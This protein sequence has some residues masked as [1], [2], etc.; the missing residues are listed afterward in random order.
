MIKNITISIISVSILAC[1]L[2][3]IAMNFPMTYQGLSQ[4]YLWQTLTYFLVN[5]LYS[6]SLIAHLVLNLFLLNLIGLTFTR[7]NKKGL[8]T[9][10]FFGGAL[11]GGLAG[12]LALMQT[13]SP[14]ALYGLTPPLYALMGA[15]AHLYPRMELFVF[16][17]F[18]LRA[19][20]LFTVFLGIHLILDLANGNMV[21]LTANGSAILFGLIS[22]KYILGRVKKAPA[23]RGKVYDIKTGRAIFRDEEFMNACLDKIAKYGRGSLTFIEKIKLKRISAKLGRLSERP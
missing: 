21:S 16:G 8:L 23:L 7:E 10:I 20:P 22:A 17:L 2:P 12:A 6:L 1:I 14:H 11:V 15:F 3:F 13:H 9:F 5:P 19:K 18:P 4:G